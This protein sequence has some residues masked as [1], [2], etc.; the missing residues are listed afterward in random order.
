ML[1]HLK[2]DSFVVIAKKKNLPHDFSSVHRAIEGIWV[3]RL[4]EIKKAE[5]SDIEDGFESESS[6]Q[7]INTDAQ[8]SFDRSDMGVINQRTKDILGPAYKVKIERQLEGKRE[9]FQNKL[10]D[11][12]D[13]VKF[14]RERILSDESDLEDAEKLLEELLKEISLT[15]DKV[16]NISVSGE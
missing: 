4:V 14:T 1:D 6:S 9:A 5:F 15:K 3:D 2:E 13:D 16:A 7:N 8:T 10:R 12:K 11:I